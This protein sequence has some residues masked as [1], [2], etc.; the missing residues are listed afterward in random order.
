M[1]HINETISRIN[2]HD[3]IHIIGCMVIVTLKG[4][5]WFYGIHDLVLLLIRHDDEWVDGLDYFGL[6]GY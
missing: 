5:A 1:A 6:F 3:H 4:T 2:A